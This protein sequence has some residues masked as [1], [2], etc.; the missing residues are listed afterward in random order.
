[1]VV[2]ALMCPGALIALRCH[3][4]IYQRYIPVRVTCHQ[5]EGSQT[6]QILT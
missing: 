5:C 2:G 3:L 1:M 4:E 6:S